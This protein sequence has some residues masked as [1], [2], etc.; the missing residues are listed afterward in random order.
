MYSSLLE[1]MEIYIRIV[2]LGSFSRAADALHLHRPAVSKALAQLEEEL[3][4]KL[5]H[6]TTR[7][8][9][10]TAEGEEFYRQ[11]R[12]LLV[13]VKD[14]MAGFSPAQPPRGRLR[15]DV[16]LALAHNM[17]VPALAEFQLQYPEIEI[18]LSASDRKAD[19]I[20]EG[21]DCV[22]RLG[23]LADSG[24]VV[25][26]LGQIKMVSCAAP[27][28]LN[29]YGLPQKPDDLSRHKAV[30]F[31]SE[32]SREVMEWTFR[33]NGEVVSCRP[34]GT[35][36]VNNSDILLDC[37]LAGSG[38]IQVPY[39]CVERHIRSG[40]LVEILADFPPA[41]KD[42]SLL[43]P[44]RHYLPPKVRVFIDWVSE[45]FRRRRGEY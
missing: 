32:H 2:E 23:R 33:Q 21:V 14:I 11:A 26:P 25:R 15:L 42:V 18:A 31:F 34:A 1:Q 39:L 43:W 9:R 22:I 20:A 6:R 19:M 37:A 41:A 16:P 7:K 30:N 40:R 4:V 35:I 28:Y 12:L 27:D 17:L 3:G 36:L 5:L 13:H 44:D 45:I 10:M 38:I 24:L 8:L 29:H